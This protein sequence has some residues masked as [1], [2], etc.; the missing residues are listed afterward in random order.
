[1]CSIFKRYSP[2]LVAAA[3]MV[4]VIGCSGRNGDTTDAAGIDFRPIRRMTDVY[5]AYLAEHR[6]Q[7]PPNEQAFRE[8]VD[9]N[10]EL[11]SRYELT[12]EQMFVSPRDG[13]PLVWVYG[14]QPPTSRLGAC[15][16]YEKNSVDGKRLVLASRGMYEEIDE[17]QFRALFPNAQ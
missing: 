15:F 6:N 13:G 1:M 11:L 14:K 7:A 10:Q 9:A 12:A 4:A 2:L 3:Y 5:S 8:F 17:S 16:A